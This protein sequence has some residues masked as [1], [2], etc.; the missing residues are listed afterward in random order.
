MKFKQWLN[1]AE[2]DEKVGS[3][4][5]EIGMGT[6]YND[7]PVQPDLRKSRRKFTKP[8]FRNKILVVTDDPP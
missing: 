4:S 2:S 8:K 6:G 7:D 1:E 3:I 5:S